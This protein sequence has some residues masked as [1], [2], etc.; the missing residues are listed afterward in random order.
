MGHGAEGLQCE[1]RRLELFSARSGA[2]AR[3]SSSEDE[4]G[5]IS[6]FKQRLCFA[7]AFWNGRDPILKERLFGLTGPQGNHGEDVKE[8]Y[9][10]RTTRLRMASCG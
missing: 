6:D 1:R 4:I 5:G 9:L 3:L 10:Y 7:F 8:L 2:L